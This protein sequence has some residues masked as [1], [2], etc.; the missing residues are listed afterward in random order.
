MPIGTL[1]LLVFFV[2]RCEKFLNLRI[3][4]S[5]QVKVEVNQP[6]FLFFVRITII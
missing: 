1:E 4:T 3:L 6:I 2:L 5:K